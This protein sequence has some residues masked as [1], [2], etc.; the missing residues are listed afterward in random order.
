MMEGGE[1]SNSLPLYIGSILSVG[2]RKCAEGNFQG[3]VVMSI[4]DL[5]ISDPLDTLLVMCCTLLYRRHTSHRQSTAVSR[6]V[7]P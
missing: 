4:I 3:R 7:L 2:L 6:G 5:L 1:H